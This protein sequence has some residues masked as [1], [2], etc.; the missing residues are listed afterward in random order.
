MQCYKL[1]P[2]ELNAHCDMQILS[3]IWSLENGANTLFVISYPTNLID[4][5]E[6]IIITQ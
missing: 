2:Y 3:N 4:F 1:I 5:G 6:Y